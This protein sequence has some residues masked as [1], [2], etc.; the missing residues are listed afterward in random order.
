MKVDFEELKNLEKN[1][2]IDNKSADTIKS[3]KNIIKKFM[4]SEETDIFKYAENMRYRDEV[5]HFKSALKEVYNLDRTSFSKLKDI[6]DKKIKRPR[7]IRE[8]TQ[9]LSIWRTV[10]AIRNKKLKLAFRLSFVSGLRI[11]ELAEIKKTD[12]IFDD[13]EK[14]IIVNVRKGKGN[15]PRYL[16]TIMPDEYLYNGLNELVK[17]LNEN[18]QVFYSRSYLGSMATKYNFKNHDLRANTLRVIYYSD[19]QE[20]EKTIEVCQDFLGHSRKS[21]TYLY[22]LNKDINPTGT[23]FDI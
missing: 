1:M 16:W 3:Y 8:Q 22:Y 18:D 13:K 4:T 7:K 15:K 9:L 11:K 17:D 14:K 20:K 2:K 19:S 5:S 10:N 6:H 12:L 23:K 21:K